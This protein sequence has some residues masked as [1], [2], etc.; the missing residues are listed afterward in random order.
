[1][2]KLVQLTYAAFKNLRGQQWLKQNKTCPILK[3]PLPYNK[4]VFDHKHKLKAETIGQDGKGLLR[5]VV[6]NQANVM[7]GK[8]TNMYKRYGLHKLISLPELLR[9]IADY[10]ENPPME[11]KYIH[12]ME[13][14]KEK[15]LGKRDFNKICKYYFYIYPDR[16]T[17]PVYPKRGKTNKV[18]DELLKKANEIESGRKKSTT[19]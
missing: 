8:I 2:E 15:A 16:K 18:F 10:I 13:R 1:M 14:P 19:P 11:Q 5:G 6:H 7:E 4:A 3:Q 12:P 9:N 17:L